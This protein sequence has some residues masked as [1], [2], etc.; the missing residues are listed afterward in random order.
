M[1]L[2]I[3]PLIDPAI[4]DHVFLMTGHGAGRLFKPIDERGVALTD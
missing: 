4:P 1:G 2:P 3:A